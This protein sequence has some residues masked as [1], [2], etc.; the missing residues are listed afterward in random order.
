[1]HHQQL[2]VTELL[3]DES[4]I[5]FC[6]RQNERDVQYWQKFIAD[7]PEKKPLIEEAIHE[8]SI[9][10]TSL[11]NADL[12]EQ[13]QKLRLKLDAGV[14][15]EAA[16]VVSLHTTGRSFFRRFR[17]AISA[18]AILL[19][20]AGYFLWKQPTPPPAIAKQTEYAS[21]QGERKSF[22]LPDGTQVSLNAGS[23]IT[24]GDAYGQA[25]RDVYLK[26]E[27]FF[28]VQHNK[29]VP[30]I[31][32]TNDMDVKALGTAFN[33]R[34]YHGEK[35]ETALLRGLVEVT[36]KKDNN[37]K[38]LLHPDEK[39]SWATQPKANAIPAV[40]HPSKK[41]IVDAAGVKPVKKL[42][43][44]SVKEV[45]WIENKLAF[46]DDAFEDIVPQLARWYNVEI[47]FEVEEMKH[48]HFTA[49]FKKEKLEQVLDILG[50]IRPFKYHFDGKIIIITNKLEH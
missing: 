32:H 24:I 5:N 36:L 26:G 18:A 40:P 25:T 9:L 39:I 29:Q 4:F 20:A 28:E 10:F 44:G 46:E 16:P 2:T 21:K 11:A 6:R 48:Y 23:T 30:F 43:D 31:V 45:A 13:M 42:D 19:L 35:S 17:F 14:A 1:M 27:A 37:R 8:Y 50:T 12:E 34:S 33:V 7:N 3:K 41:E 38:V 47:V 22:Q 15:S 49:T